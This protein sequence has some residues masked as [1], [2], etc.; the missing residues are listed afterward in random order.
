MTRRSGWSSFD[1]EQDGRRTY[2]SAK[3]GGGECH[4]DKGPNGH[5]IQFGT[6]R[7]VPR[8]YGHVL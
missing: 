4:Q 5:E 3:E 7:H 6:Y 1:D 8:P 2:P